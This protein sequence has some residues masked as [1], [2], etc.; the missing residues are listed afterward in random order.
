VE[1]RAR[2]ALLVELIV[3]WTVWSHLL[4]SDQ[5]QPG[6]LKIASGEMVTAFELITRV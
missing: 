6:F 5:E 4:M 2:A 3:S 1:N